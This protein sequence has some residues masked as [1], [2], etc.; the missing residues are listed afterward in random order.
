[1]YTHAITQEPYYDERLPEREDKP[2]LNFNVKRRPI[3]DDA[4]WH[5]VSPHTQHT[6]SEGSAE[7][8][9]VVWT[10]VCVCPCG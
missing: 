2:E 3:T 8:A 9:M 10:C 1:M 7:H 4:T 5:A 6:C